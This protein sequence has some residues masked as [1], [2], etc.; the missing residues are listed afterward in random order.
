MKLGDQRLQY[1]QIHMMSYWGDL[2][3]SEWPSGLWDFDFRIWER[4]LH[5]LSQNHPKLWTSKVQPPNVKNWVWD[6][7]NHVFPKCCKH[8][9]SDNEDHHEAFPPVSEFHWI[10][11]YVCICLNLNVV[12][13]V[14]VEMRN[15]AKIYLIDVY[16]VLKNL[17]KCCAFLKPKFSIVFP[18]HSMEWWSQL[19]K[20]PGTTTQLHGISWLQ[21]GAPVRWK[22]PTVGF[23]MHNSTEVLKS[24]RTMKNFASQR[25]SRL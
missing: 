20:A 8:T 1:L 19:L 11:S 12:H 5:P 10:A 24:G 17:V 4:N 6:M 3:S 18:K 7:L 14:Y 25:M 22:C 15:M 2:P 16:R 23:W 21:A 9:K 13:I